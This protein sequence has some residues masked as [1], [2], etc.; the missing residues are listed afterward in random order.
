LQK[1]ARDTLGTFA[2]RGIVQ[3]AFARRLLQDYLPTHPGY[4]GE[5]VWI[6]AMLELWLRSHA[7]DWR[8]QT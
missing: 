4:Y 7:P 3:P 6:F 2:N 8:A 1:L 5:L